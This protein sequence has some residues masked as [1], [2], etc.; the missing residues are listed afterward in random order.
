MSDEAATTAGTSADTETTTTPTEAG[1]EGHH[2][3]Y[4]SLSEEDQII[5]Q[6]RAEAQNAVDDKAEPVKE[7][8]AAEAKPKAGETPAKPSKGTKF[9]TPEAAVEAITAAW[10]AGDVDKLSKLTGKPKSF[11]QLNDAKWVAFRQEQAQVRS[12]KAA[13]QQER[14][15][16]T[17]DKALAKQEYGAAI[18]AARAYREGDYEKFVVLVGELAEE[19][20]DVAQRKVIEGHI[21]LDPNTKALRKQLKEQQA[22]IEELKNPKAKPVAEPTPAERRQTYE[23]AVK[24]VQTELGT[25]Q[26]SKVKDYERLVLSKVRDSWSERENTYTLSFEEAGDQIV[27]ERRQEAEALGHAAPRKVPAKKTPELPSRSRAA[28]ARPADGERWMTEDLDDDE[29]IA[30]L[31][32]DR[33]AGR[34]K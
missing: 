14:Q 19:A 21:A 34:L 18:Q 28:D 31:Q 4:G 22:Q 8:P 15:K 3:S 10:E 16:L 13:V 20:Y 12:D 23:N 26:V 27:D 7:K 5:E 2:T 6:I 29:I 25:H 24:A 32:R 33:K 30:S 11:F 17:S 9:E 1:G